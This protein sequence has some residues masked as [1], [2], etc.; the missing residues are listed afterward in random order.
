M[1]FWIHQNAHTL[2]GIGPKITKHPHPH[3]FET[4]VKYSKM[5][6]NI[7]FSSN[8]SRRLA[9]QTKQM[10]NPEWN[11][12]NGVGL[13][14]IRCLI[15]DIQR[16]PAWRFH[17]YVRAR[18][19]ETI[20]CRCLHLV[21]HCSEWFAKKQK[22]P[23]KKKETPTKRTIFDWDVCFNACL[24]RSCGWYLTKIYDLFPQ[25]QL[26]PKRELTPLWFLF[27]PLHSFQR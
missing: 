4:N 6:K 3:A 27:F 20:P 22:Q 19:N 12:C 23:R 1:F 24:I 2:N 25:T 5:L 7:S 21:P 14:S 17:A 13:T 16:T 9:R 15:S 18:A 26:E 8:R 10:R 11:R